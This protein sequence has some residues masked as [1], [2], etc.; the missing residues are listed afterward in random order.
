[1]HAYP[2]I[3]N[4]GL[5]AFVVMQQHYIFPSGSVHGVMCAIAFG[6]SVAACPLDGSYG[7]FLCFTRPSRTE[8]Q[9]WTAGC[10]DTQLG[11]RSGK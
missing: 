7:S 5:M 1:M 10:V 4:V 3:F 11:C 6:Q 8:L 2:P 9:V